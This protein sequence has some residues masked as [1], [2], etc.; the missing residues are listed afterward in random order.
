ME[1]ENGVL[2]SGTASQARDGTMTHFQEDKCW[3]AFQDRIFAEN[4]KD[5]LGGKNSFYQNVIKFTVNFIRF[6]QGMQLR[7]RIYLLSL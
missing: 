3:H 4:F 2:N 7:G 6:S 1:A 5:S